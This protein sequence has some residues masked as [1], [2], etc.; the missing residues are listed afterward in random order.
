MATIVS[1]LPVT[2]SMAFHTSAP[3]SSTPPERGTPPQLGGR[4]DRHMTAQEHPDDSVYKSAKSTRPGWANALIIAGV[5]LI[6]SLLC[7]ILGSTFASVVLAI[8]VVIAAIVAG[9]FALSRV[10]K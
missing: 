4:Y 1:R 3:T 10:R 7:G 8:G 9:I 2:V 5:L 6:A